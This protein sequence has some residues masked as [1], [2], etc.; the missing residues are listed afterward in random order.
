M[1]EWLDECM[2]YIIDLQSHWP[3]YVFIMWKVHFYD[4]VC[5]MG[6][7]NWYFPA[8]GRMYPAE[9]KIRGAEL[10]KRSRAAPSRRPKPPTEDVEFSVANKR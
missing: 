9:M 6:L 5:G 4:P 10:F 3:T 8:R 2:T 1:E 7:M